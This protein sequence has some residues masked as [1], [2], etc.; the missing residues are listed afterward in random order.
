[1]VS[2]VT[3]VD[4]VVVGAGIA[5]LAA[6]RT[7]RACGL[8]LVVLEARNRVGGRLLSFP[9]DGGNLDIGATWFWPDEPRISE[10]VADLSIATHP[11]HLMGDALYQDVHGMQRLAGNPVDVSSWRITA[12]AQHLAIAVALEFPQHTIRFDHDVA[13]I[14]S[15]ADHVT[16]QT[17]TGSFRGKH[18]ILAVP[19][20][21]AV[22][23]IEFAPNLDRRTVEVAR[24]TP[25]WMGAMTK[26][27]AQFR[28]P[29]W[30]DQG[31][32]GA[33]I[34]HVGPMREIHDMS[35]R[36]GSPAVLFG[37]VPP[38]PPGRPTVTTAEVL[39]QLVDMF[40]RDGGSPDKLVIHDWRD[41]QHTSPPGVE[42][43]QAYELFGHSC[44]TAPGLGGRLHWASTE[45]SVTH[46]GH[47]EGAL[48][49]ADRAAKA[50]V[51]AIRG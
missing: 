24:A 39:T 25:V 28:A 23:A 41:E 18:L 36:D 15:T 8:D 34:S 30:R 38:D 14:H 17:A 47:I 32:A 4:V 51:S 44:Y 22:S 10:L 33:V 12:G 48:A 20:A 49:A 42:D 26:V 35:G 6:A 43:L 31:L 3:D 45:A 19:P 50:V 13:E 40:G 9:A 46:P 1:L 29:F 11:Q 7:L 16:A 27:V 2:T 21:L 5:G 37:F